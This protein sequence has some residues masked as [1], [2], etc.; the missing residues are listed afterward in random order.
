[1]DLQ[2]EMW[3]G[4]WRSTMEHN[5]MG[6]DRA[7]R[8]PNEGEHPQAMCIARS[9]FSVPVWMC[10]EMSNQAVYRGDCEAHFCDHSTS[11]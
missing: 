11:C 9:T 3:R 10:I 2:K 4:E 1:M 7:E 8:G 6:I 5:T